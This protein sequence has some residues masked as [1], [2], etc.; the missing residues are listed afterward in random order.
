[1]KLDLREKCKTTRSALESNYVAEANKIIFENITHMPEF[2]QAENIMIYISFS[3]EVDT[4]RLIEYC[5][6]N[7]KKVYVPVTFSMDRGIKA[8][9][10]KS[11]DDLKVGAYG[12]LEPVEHSFVEKEYIDMCIVPG[13]AFDLNGHRIGYGGGY[14]DRFLCDYKGFTAGVAFD[15]CIIESTCPEEYDVAVKAVVTE[16]EVIRNG[17]YRRTQYKL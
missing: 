3:S 1:M 13:L 17:A 6:K 16:K 11:F 12:I 15:K 5:L 2:L 7:G 4:K 8:C 10:L 14:Y 9:A